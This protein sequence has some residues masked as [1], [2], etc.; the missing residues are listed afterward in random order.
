MADGRGTSG[1][2]GVALVAVTYVYFLIFAQFA[3]LSRLAELNLAASNLQIVMAVMAAGGILLSLLVPRVAFIPSPARRLRIAF[4][5]SAAAALLSI[6]PLGISGAVAVA[7][8]IGAALGLLTVT[9]VT[10]LRVWT[11]DSNSILKVGL[12]TGIGYFLCNVPPLFTATPQIQA[13]V[14]ALLCLVGMVLASSPSEAF[15]TR[16]LPESSHFSFLRALGAFAALVWLDSAAFFIIQHAPA[17]K[18]GTWLGSVHLWTNACLH[19]GAA[20]GAAWLLQRRRSGMVLAVAFLSL[21]FACVLLS[22][23]ALALPASIFYPIGVSL[24]S[25][26]LVAYPSF[27]SPAISTRDRGIQAG[28]IYAVAGWVGSALGIGMG[29]NLGHVPTAFVA[30]AGT[31]V[32]L[33]AFIQLSQTRT[34]EITALAIALALAFTLYRLLPKPSQQ[35]SAVERGRR[36]YIGEGCIHCHSQY[37]RPDSP[38]VLMWGPV[39]DL[40]QVHAQQ[41]PLI[42]NRRQGPDLTQVGARRSALWLEAHLIDPAEVSGGSIMPPFTFLFRDQRG[43]DLVAYLASLQSGDTQQHLAE[44]QAWQSTAAAVS[45]ANTAEGQSLYQLQCA[46]C[47]DANGRTRRQ[48]QSQF[49]RPPNSLFTGPFTHQQSAISADR[50]DQMA[51]ITKFGIPGTDMPGHEYLSDQQVASLTLFL[52]QRSATFNHHP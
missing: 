29:Q 31:V 26:A 43:D 1:W 44:E 28:W 12:G 9:L 32:L 34:R 7:F 42:G 48:F 23:P 45:N 41:P 2:R 4:A 47:H 18:A 38:D 24:Y 40:Q 46:T 50:S 11:G 25:V 30:F 39:E 10:H 35:L 49:K 22:D 20:I 52:T 16:V 33:P 17:L 5:A 19:L 27:L 15:A 3:F 36:V 14:A 8:L 6:L 13:V 51:R 37:V 21:G